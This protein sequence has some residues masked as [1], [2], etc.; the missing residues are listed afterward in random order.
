MAL[1]DFFRRTPPPVVDTASPARNTTAGLIPTWQVGTPQWSDWKVETAI[2]EG[3]NVN[4]WVY[5]CVSKRVDAVS[6]VPW[7]VERHTKDG[8]QPDLDHPLNNLLLKPNPSMSWEEMISMMV[9]HLDLAG[10]AYWRE[11]KVGDGRVQ[12]LWPI[13]PQRVTIVPGFEALIERYELSN[14]KLSIA[15]K[16]MVHVKYT[17]PSDLFYGQSPLQ[18]A[19]KSVDVDNAAAG[20]QK[21]SMQNRGIPDGVFEA[22]DQNMTDEQFEDAQQIIKD[23]YSGIANAREPFVTSGF[24]FVPMSLTP[25]EVDFIET[26]QLTRA[27]ICAVYGVPVEIVTGMGS[28]NRASSETVRKTFWLDTI[29]PLLD[30]ISQALT[31]DL[32][33]DYGT[34]IRLTYDTSGVPALQQ[35]Q[36]EKMDVARALWGMG[37][38]FNVINAKLELGFD[39]IDGG[40]VGYLSAGLLPANMDFDSLL[41]PDDSQD[42][43]TLIEKAY[44]SQDRK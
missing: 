14:P 13:L 5:A 31:R 33:H 34:D 26:R 10:N 6:S 17:S 28:A 1:L 32:A 9:M 29:I 8:W 38:P 24:K 42:L 39:D 4:P 3:F 25:A 12:E 7:V 16:D 40:E 30:E 19:G 11:V 22:V 23:K 21:I 35:N 44:G 2:R 41:Q 18:A 20:W 43:K 27:E 37:V 15:A 36:A